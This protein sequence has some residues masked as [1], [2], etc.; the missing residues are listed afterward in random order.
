MCESTS[1][2]GMPMCLLLFVYLD[3]HLFSLSAC[4]C[5]SLFLSL[6]ELLSVTPKQESWPQLTTEYQKGNY[7]EVIDNLLWISVISTQLEF[8]IFS[9]YYLLLIQFAA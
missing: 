4:V 6:P 9:L 3:K 8:I 5:F 7:S 1:S 2:V